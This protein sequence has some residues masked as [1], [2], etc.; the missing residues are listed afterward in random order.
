[1]DENYQTY[2][3][4][5]AR[6][7]LAETYRT[8]VETLQ[9]SPKYQ[10]DVEGQRQ[11]A[12]FPGYCAMTPPASEETK[13]NQSVYDRLANLQNELLRSVEA[14]F[15]VGVPPESFHI[16]LADL[17]WDAAYRE[18]RRN[19]P[20]F[21]EQ[22]RFRIAESFLAYKEARATPATP[23]RWQVAGLMLR[24]RA[25]NAC[26]LPQ[27]EASYEAVVELRRA[28][29]Q[30]AN[31]IALGIEQQYVFTAHVTLGY[32]GNTGNNFDRLAWCDRL[33][34]LSD[35]SLASEPP[36][37]EIGRVELRKFDDMTRFAREADFP[38]LEL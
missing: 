5:A 10:G 32:F 3:N 15:L 18:V 34:E 8:Q 25:V 20:D 24:P 27:D 13:S 19:N 1:M 38:A 36:L 9:E 30:N 21:Q 37:L 12:P 26:L 7:M 16:T 29:Y 6:L 22:L 11:P 35:R 2:V 14:G 4:R 23:V 17:I 33:V 28:I 31:L